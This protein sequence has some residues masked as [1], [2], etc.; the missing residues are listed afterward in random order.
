MAPVQFDSALRLPLF[1]KIALYQF[2]DKPFEKNSQLEQEN[3]QLSLFIRQ[4]GGEN[5]DG[6]HLYGKYSRKDVFRI[7]GWGNAHQK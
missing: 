1:A 5:C 6:F 3:I 7:L 4:Q 2:I